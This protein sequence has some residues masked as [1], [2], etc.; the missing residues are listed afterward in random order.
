M[1][2]SSLS[3]EETPRRDLRRQVALSLMP[4]KIRSAMR[5]SD[6]TPSTTVDRY[7]STPLPS[8]ANRFIPLKSDSSVNAKVPHQE[9]DEDKL[10]GLTSDYDLNLFKSA[11]QKAVAVNEE[12][13]LL[14]IFYTIYV[15][16]LTA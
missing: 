5:G 6:I 2:N 7:K 4:E 16:W 14:S 3:S 1:A 9:L 12:V 15:M 8:S 13:G 10:T 11:W